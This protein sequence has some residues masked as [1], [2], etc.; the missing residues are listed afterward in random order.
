[1]RNKILACAIALFSGLAVQSAQAQQA[2]VPTAAPTAPSGCLAPNLAQYGRLSWFLGLHPS[3]DLL[4]AWCRLQTLPGNVR[5]NVQFPV[6]NVHQSWD[7]SFTTKLPATRIVELVQSM[8]PTDDSNKI[9]ETGVPFGDVL[10][11]TSQLMAPASPD[12]MVLGFAETH[13]AAK[14]VVLWEPL[15]LRVRPV[16]LAG[17]QFTLSVYLR[18]NLGLLSMALA[19]RATDVRVKA[20]TG[21]FQTGN[22]FRTAC[23]E[24]FPACSEL[25]DVSIVHLPLLVDTVRLEATGEN[26]T[27]AAIAIGQEL[28]ARNASLTPSDPMSSFDRANGSGRYTLHDDQGTM[29]FIAEGSGGTKRIEIV[30]KATDGEGSML[31]RLSKIA[32]DYRAGTDKKTPQAPSVPDSLGRL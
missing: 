9:S 30:Y 21:R 27:A 6:T 7:T 13:P 12:G 5:F 19:G 20:W 26:M 16:A 25:P 8:I 3:D 10:A 24:L 28:Y 23:S 4:S 32:D 29:E 2:Q 18:P 31:R 22:Y 17:Q 11:R 15:G 1:M 14:Q